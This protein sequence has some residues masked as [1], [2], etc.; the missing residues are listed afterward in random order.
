MRGRTFASGTW[1]Q[2][3]SR[4]ASR[5]VTKKS[6]SREIEQAAASFRSASPRKASHGNTVDPKVRALGA[7]AEQK[8]RA[9]GVTKARLEIRASGPGHEPHVR[10]DQVPLSRLGALVRVLSELAKHVG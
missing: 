9:A 7:A 5:V 2:K 10:I 8:V 4:C 3:R 1:L 6:S